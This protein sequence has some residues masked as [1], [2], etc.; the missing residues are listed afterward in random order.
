VGL[1]ARCR[2]HRKEEVKET[3]AIT[4]TTDDVKRKCMIDSSEFDSEIS[5]LISEMQ[6]AVEKRI[7]AEH[8]D[9]IGDTK[10]QALLK[11]GILEIISCEFLNEMNRDRSETEEFKAA[12]ISFGAKPVN[13]DD[14]MAQGERRL[15][16][17]SVEGSSPKMSG[18][19]IDS[20]DDA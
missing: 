17:Y 14:L 16:P 1:Q 15:R 5:A 13:G 18:S 12:G 19:A 11:L 6:P 10:L 20:D 7:L 2:L 9:N 8:L 4:I 3:L